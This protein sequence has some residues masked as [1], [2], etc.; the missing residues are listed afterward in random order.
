MHE[1]YSEVTLGSADELWA[2]LGPAGALCMPPSDPIFRGQACADWELVPSVLRKDARRF[3]PASW[4]LEREADN[5]VFVELLLLRSFVLYGDEIGL[6]LPTDLAMELR[7]EKFR[8]RPELTDPGKWPGEDPLGLLAMAQHHG[9]PT[10]LLD[11]TRN[12]HAAIFFAA[13]D[14]LRRI[15]D[16]KS[17]GRLAVWA[18]DTAAINLYRENVR[19]FRPLGSI[20]PHLAAQSGVFTVQMFG[21][22]RGEPLDVK[23][24]ETVF[25]RLPNSPLT[26]FTVPTKESRRLVQYCERVGV[27]GARM[28][29]SADG[30]GQAVLRNSDLWAAEEVLHGTRSV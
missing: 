22:V 6:V 15:A 20:S 17:D 10:R 8:D 26:K 4:R 9:V 25:A 5:Q 28:F 23:P 21:G 12:P 29:P 3:L 30:A 24:L 7:G 14:A 2:E 16:G 18:L 19:T 1:P 27:S 13:T 11:W